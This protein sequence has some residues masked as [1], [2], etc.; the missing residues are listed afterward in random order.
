MLHAGTAPP[1]DVYSL[2]LYHLPTLNAPSRLND[3]LGLNDAAIEDTR[4]NIWLGKS[5][6]GCLDVRLRLEVDV[7][8]GQRE[9]AAENC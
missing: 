3:L 7:V 6:V 2:G 4:E 9:V 8:D 1:A 5:A